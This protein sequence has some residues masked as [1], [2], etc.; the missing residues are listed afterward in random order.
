MAEI[1][2]NIKERKAGVMTGPAQII[3][4]G[5]GEGPAFSPVG[6]GYRFLAPGEQTGGVYMHSEAWVLKSD[7]PILRI[8]CVLRLAACAGHAR[9]H[10]ATA[11][12]GSL[13]Q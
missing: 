1:L 8:P 9:G 11:G 5:P 12:R 7:S 3:H 4:I 2:V 13:S 10:C 6:D